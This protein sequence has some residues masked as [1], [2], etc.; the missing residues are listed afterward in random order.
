MHPIWRAVHDL[1]DQRREYNDKS[2]NQDPEYGWTIARISEAVVEA[3]GFARW[4]H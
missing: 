4:P 1:G 2:A 3:A